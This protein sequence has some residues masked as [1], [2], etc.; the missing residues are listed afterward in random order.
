[1]RNIRGWS[2]LL[3]A[4]LGLIAA[5]CTDDP[6]ARPEPGIWIAL[7][8]PV[9]SPDASSYRPLRV[10]DAVSGKE[11]Q[12]GP[13]ALY[14]AVKWSPDGSR[15][16]AFGLEGNPGPNS[17]IHL[18][19]WNSTGKQVIDIPYK[20]GDFEAF[21]QSLEWSPDSTRLASLLQSG[22]VKLYDASGRERGSVSS[23]R[24]ADGS[25]D[26]RGRSV[27]NPWSP[28]S[29][30]MSEVIQGAL[31]LVDRDGRVVTY[32]LPSFPFEEEN[33]TELLALGW[34]GPGRPRLLA[35]D[36]SG[37]SSYDGTVTGQTID[38]GEPT[39]FDFGQYFMSEQ[40]VAE[41]A[42]L[43]PDRSPGAKTKSA[44]GN[45]TIIGLT[46]MGDH[47]LEPSALT[48]RIQLRKSTIDVEMGKVRFLGPG[49][50]DVVVVSGWKGELPAT[51]NAATPLPSFTPTPTIDPR[52]P[53]PPP[54]R[55][56][57]TSPDAGTTPIPYPAPRGERVTPQL[58]LP[59]FPGAQEIDG[60]T[61]TRGRA[62]GAVQMFATDA[63]ES[64][65][66]QFFEK[67]LLANGFRPT[68]GGSGVVGE[69]HGYVKGGDSVLISTEYIPRPEDELPSGALPYGFQGKGVRFLLGNDGKL[70]FFV[71]TNHQ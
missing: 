10:L 32:A 34:S 58:S 3:L 6:P 4:A 14:V 47:R 66:L 70:W 53:T 35:R 45:A 29:Q 42:R 64:A 37:S 38:W 9:V 20:D 23:L 49:P 30:V 40:E 16:A 31:R 65:V 50:I 54:D 15:L 18:W 52:A 5:A 28:D 59:T 12:I 8:Q 46:G 7:A 71:V 13:P 61:S 56:I 19:I 17:S 69:R 43:R 55:G 11:R 33:F 26:G 36:L 39:P 2:L 68:G 51:R 57:R 63:S 44:D 67:Y 1:M 25:F 24:R 41:L 27:G 21:P 22:G 62:V 48:L 60:Y